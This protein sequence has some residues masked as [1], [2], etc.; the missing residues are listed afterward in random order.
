MRIG[1]RAKIG[2]FVSLG[3]LAGIGFVGL[4]ALILGPA[5]TT[6]APKS[7]GS[8]STSSSGAVT[9]TGSTLPPD[10]T[11]G[12]MSNTQQIPASDHPVSLGSLA[13]LASLVIA[14]ATAL[15][16]VGSLFVARRSRRSSA[17]ILSDQV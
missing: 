8:N 15:A 1:T 17:R 5:H 13:G 10:I 3:I 14:P 16:L 7:N 9:A 2:F 11:R 12:N 6:V 4:P